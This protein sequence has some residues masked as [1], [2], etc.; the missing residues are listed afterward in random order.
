ML[1]SLNRQLR[2]SRGLRLELIVRKGRRKARHHHSAPAPSL[3][4]AAAQGRPRSVRGRGCVRGPGGRRGGDPEGMEVACSPVPWTQGTHRRHL[5]PQVHRSGRND[6][7]WLPSSARW[8][9]RAGNGGAG[10]R[11]RTSRLR[12]PPAQRGAARHRWRSQRNG[13]SRAG[14]HSRLNTASP[15]EAVAW[16]RSPCGILGREVLF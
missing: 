4:A 11:Q 13:C 9:M 12:R 15:A 7:S 2:V 1:P 14:S 3:R 5:L 8:Q 10:D 16:A 6:D